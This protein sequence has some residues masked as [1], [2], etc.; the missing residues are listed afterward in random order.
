MINVL[1]THTICYKVT[2]SSRYTSHMVNPL[3]AVCAFIKN[4][5]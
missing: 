4:K 5:K 2:F 1:I 3:A